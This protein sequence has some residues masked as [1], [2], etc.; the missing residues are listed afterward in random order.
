[1]FIYRAADI[2]DNDTVCNSNGIFLLHSF[3]V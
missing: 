2:N 3:S 1:M